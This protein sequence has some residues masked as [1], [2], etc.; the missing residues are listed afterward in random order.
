VQV[1]YVHADH[2]GTPIRITQPSDNARRW[3]WRTDPFGTLASNEDP[4]SLGVLPYNL[5]FLGQLF[6]G[7]AGLHQNWRRDYSPA[8]GKYV[9]SDPV[10]LEGGINVYAYAFGNPVALVDPTGLTPPLSAPA[11]L[12]NVVRK[13]WPSPGIA[14]QVSGAAGDFARNYRDMR[15]ANTIGADKYFHCKA[16]CQATQRGWIGENTACLI[17][18][19]RE[20]VDQ[21]LKWDP[22]SA[23]K[24]DQLANLAGRT[25]AASG[26]ACEMVC[27]AF[28]PRGLS[29]AY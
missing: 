16:N 21:Y 25:G 20:T 19:S 12:R 28:R 24:A 7:Q 22:A 10:G 6:D 13:V 27:S 4:E 5:R 11:A 3:Q 9:E 23:S 8:T 29:S 26:R 17:S 1:L 18:N 2:L 14:N 15:D